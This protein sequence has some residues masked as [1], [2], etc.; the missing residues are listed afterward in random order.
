MTLKL[1]HAFSINFHFLVYDPTLS[2]SSSYFS[3]DVSYEAGSINIIPILQIRTL[4]QMLVTCPSHPAMT[5][6]NQLSNVG[7]GSLLS[8]L[9]ITRPHCFSIIYYELYQNLL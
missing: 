9:L 7:S 5:L 4:R 2:A 8:V 6:Q 1:F 3:D